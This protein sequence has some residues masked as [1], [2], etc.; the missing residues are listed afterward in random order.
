[1]GLGF[2]F[3]NLLY[4]AVALFVAVILW[5]ATQGFRSVEGSMNLPISLEGYDRGAVVVVEQS[6]QEVNLRIVGSQAALRRAEQ[7]LKRY[8]VSL[9]QVRS[10]ELRLGV[11][12]QQL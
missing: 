11:D 12:P 4:K 9:A 7:Q 10:G 6:A 2:L 3:D 5:A 1:M 8:P